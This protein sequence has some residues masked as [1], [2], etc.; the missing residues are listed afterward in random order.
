M[1]RKMSGIGAIIVIIFVLLSLL[2]RNANGPPRQ[3]SRLTAMVFWK[4]VAFALMLGTAAAT[5]PV[6][7]AVLVAPMVIVVAPGLV[8]EYLVVPL[9]LPR[10][11]YWAARCLWTMEVAREAEAGAA[12]YGALALAL[13]RKAPAKEMIDW[14]EFK[15]KNAHPLRGAAVTTL[16]LLAAMRGD[17]RRARALLLVVDPSER[18]FV[19]T[20]GRAVARDWLVA[21]AARIGNWREVIRLGRPGYGYDNGLRWSYCMARIA[22]RVS[23]APRGA[24]DWQVWLIWLMAPRR[25][26]TLPLLRRALAVP[27][28]TEPPDVVAPPAAEALPQALAAFADAL[29]D[30]SARAPVVLAVAAA[31]VE[32]SLEAAATGA[33]IAERAE[34]LGAQNDAEAVVAGMRTRLA[35]LL[36]PLLEDIPSLAGGSPRSPILGQAV[37]QV[38]VRLFRDIEAQC[39]DFEDRRKREDFSSAAAEWE[40]WATMRDAADRLLALSPE[41]EPVLFQAMYSPMC[42]FAVFE[43][44]TCKRITLGYAIF[45]WLYRHAQLDA[46]A[47]RL[48]ESNMKASDGYR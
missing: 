31:G 40:A 45:S 10:V 16:G 29:P 13:A 24:R 48:L 5:A 32:L 17:R 30:R 43:H 14:L 4:V 1:D 8:I 19:S 46:S 38:R 41:S 15:V 9:G 42:N 6:G 7:F 28:A 33:T 11:S 37:D 27:R 44:N 21:N 25:R 47:L 18:T 3:A 20:R 39:K 26:A 22:E 36:V 12:M 23:G 2:R 34:A 35:D